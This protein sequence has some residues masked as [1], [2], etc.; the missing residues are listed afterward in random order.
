M[1]GCETPK[2]RR[3]KQDIKIPKNKR[4]KKGKLEKT[5]KPKK[6]AKENPVKARSLGKSLD[7]KGGETAVQGGG[8]GKGKGKGGARGLGH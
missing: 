5:K 7:P 4:K 8:R 2:A 1:E 3:P 6:V